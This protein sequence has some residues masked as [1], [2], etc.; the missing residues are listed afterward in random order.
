MLFVD[1]III[2]SKNIEEYYTFK[3][4]HSFVWQTVARNFSTINL[5]RETYLH[6][7]IFDVDID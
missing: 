6:I 4:L 5:P 2:I 7:N 1:A 3:I